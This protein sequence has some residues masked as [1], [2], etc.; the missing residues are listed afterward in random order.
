MLGAHTRIDAAENDVMNVKTLCLGV[1]EL[2]EASGYEIRKMTQDGRFS[3]FVDA[4]YGAIYPALSA[5]EA[6]GLVSWREERHPGRPERKVYSITERGRV[7]LIA[8]LNEETRD[9]VIK[10]EFLFVLR[11]CELARPSHVKSELDRRIAWLEAQL[12][13]LEEARQ[14]G[15]GT[16]SS[17][18]QGY[19][20]A[21]YR[22]MHEYLVG[23]RHDIE[24]I[25]G[26]GLI[27]RDAAE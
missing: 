16:A 18:A 25:A 19:G 9:D 5:L 1:L 15:C 20:Q 21:I 23:N 11:F 6:D 8:A 7:A 22:A 27:G 14:S 17:F 26:R 4:S 12:A 13:R 2:G 3:H 10:S 24:D